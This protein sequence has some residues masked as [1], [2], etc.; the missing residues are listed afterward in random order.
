MPV[1]FRF[2]SGELHQDELV[3]VCFSLQRSFTQASV[4]R[5]EC[6]ALSGERMWTCPRD[7]SSLL[8]GGNSYRGGC[9]LLP[10]T[11]SPSLETRA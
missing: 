8:A 5:C 9:S 1:S 2:A 3:G 4:A 11:V 10:P 6:A 7:T